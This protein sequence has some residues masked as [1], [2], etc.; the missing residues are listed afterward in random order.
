MIAF[1]F[2]SG[3]HMSDHIRSSFSSS[4]ALFF[5]ALLSFA[6]PVGAEV[7]YLPM[8]GM[9]H[10]KQRVASLHCVANLRQIIS[11][12]NLWAQDNGDHYPYGLATF[13]SELGDPSLLIC[14]ADMSYAAPTNWAELDWEQVSYEWNQLPDWSNTSSVCCRCKIHNIVGW[15]EGSV[16]E[17]GG[18]RNGWPEIMAGPLDQ[19][20]SPGSSAH[21]EVRIAPDAAEPLTFQWLRNTLYYVTNIVSRPDLDNAGK[22]LW[23]TNRL[24]RFTVAALP[25]QT[26]RG[27]VLPV[28]STNDSD[29]YSVAVSNHLGTAISR[30]AGLQVM[31]EV[32]TMAVD[33]DWA[34]IICVNNLRQLG[35]LIE[36]LNGGTRP[37]R[38]EEL[39]NHFGLSLFEWPVALHCRADTNW[40]PTEDWDGLDLAQTSYAMVQHATTNPLAIYCR[41]KVHGFYLQA[42]GEVMWRPRLT[43]IEMQTGGMT[44]VG[45]RIF[46]GRRNILEGSSDLEHWLRLQDYGPEPGESVFSEAR[47]GRPRFYRIRA[48]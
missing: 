16:H 38:L 29:F 43:L 34:E 1:R 30:E 33:A 15:A 19:Y 25:N 37:Q 5:C 27:C 21:F 26:N 41:C 44:H 3:E 23:A 28:V 8:A 12:A 7:I 2:G 6:G 36:Q 40:V 11:A 20:V 9:E 42:N 22:L 4:L 10:A 13:T 14:P 39:T 35:V 48:E 45:L 24:P 17:L 31:P 18:Y 46:G 47:E 32:A